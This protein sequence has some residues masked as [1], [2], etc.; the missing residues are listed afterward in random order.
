MGVGR[1]SIRVCRRAAAIILSALDT[2][3]RI[4]S[5]REIGSTIESRGQQSVERVRCEDLRQALSVVLTLG[6]VSIAIP[7][8]GQIL[9]AARTSTRTR[10]NPRRLVRPWLI[11]GTD[12]DRVRTRTQ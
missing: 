10:V 9:N 4:V 8:I 11:A 7:L 1:I 3:G 12:A 5:D 2:A 6:Q